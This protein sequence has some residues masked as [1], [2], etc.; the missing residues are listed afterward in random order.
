MGLGVTLMWREG[1]SGTTRGTRKGVR[2]LVRSISRRESKK[3]GVG[4]EKGGETIKGKIKGCFRG[5]PTRAREIG[6]PHLGPLPNGGLY[7]TKTKAEIKIRIGRGPFR[8][9]RRAQKQKG[10][11]AAPQRSTR[12]QSYAWERGN[13][14][15]SSQSW[16]KASEAWIYNR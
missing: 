7:G 10:G 5:L 1:V 8:R 13:L 3:S 11:V 15:K 14:L 9:E 2:G 6:V 12:Y 16:A 4:E